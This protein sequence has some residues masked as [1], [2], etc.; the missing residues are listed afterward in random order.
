MSIVLRYVNLNL[1]VICI[2]VLSIFIA[3]RWY[4]YRKFGINQMLKKYGTLKMIDNLITVIIIAGAIIAC[5]M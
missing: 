2:L 4:I 3:G 1:L 5:I